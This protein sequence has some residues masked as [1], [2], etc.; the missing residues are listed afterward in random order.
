MSCKCSW[1]YLKNNSPTKSVILK[2]SVIFKGF[3]N[4]CCY[5]CSHL[6]K[7]KFSPLVI[8]TAK[9][10]TAGTLKILWQF[11]SIGHQTD[12]G[13]SCPTLHLQSLYTNR[14][15]Y[16]TMHYLLDLTGGI[17]RSDYTF[18]EIIRDQ[19]YPAPEHCLVMKYFYLHLVFST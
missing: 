11:F 3:L 2:K 10:W 18:L 1:K 8:F 14:L 17:I 15:F 12:I 5:C 4:F 19:N 6:N 13:N 9:L 7:A 16:A